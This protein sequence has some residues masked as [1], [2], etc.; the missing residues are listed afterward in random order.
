MELAIKKNINKLPDFVPTIQ[1][2]NDQLIINGFELLH[3]TND[4]ISSLSNIPL[5]A[6]H[7]DP[8]DRFLIAIA[9]YEKLTVMT[10]DSKFKLYSSLVNII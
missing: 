7:R 4:H 1:E 6:E 9:C 2:I 10:T 5:V 8:F 3:L